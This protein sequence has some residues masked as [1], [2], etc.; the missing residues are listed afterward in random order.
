MMWNALKEY[1]QKYCDSKIWI[2]PY[3]PYLPNLLIADLGIVIG[4]DQVSTNLIIVKQ[5]TLSNNKPL[6]VKIIP[7]GTR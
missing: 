6:Q 1:L 4:A 5:L 7:Q 3:L 2:W